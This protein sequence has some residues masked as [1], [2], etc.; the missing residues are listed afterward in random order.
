[1]KKIRV[2]IA[3]DHELVR[4]GLVSIISTEQEFDIIGE[5]KNGREAIEMA[6]TTRPDI[7][8]LDI[9]MPDIDGITATKEIKAN[10]P[11]VKILVLTAFQNEHEIFAAIGAGVSGYILK[12][13]SPE[14]LINSIRT[15]S[16]GQSLLNPAIAAKLTERFSPKIEEIG[17]RIT[18][19]LTDREQEVLGLIVKGY[20][21]NDIAASLR[22]RKE[23]VKTHV[24]S[25]LRKLQQSDRT[26]AAIYA[27]RMGIVELEAGRPEDC[28]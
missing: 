25:I 1:M 4:R 26:Q 14:D 3:D 27:I 6:K 13:I 5:A 7:I 11:E 19:P 22:I 15:I 8:L 17:E 12:D 18:T 28:S 2:L 23:T 21:N 16:Q 10:M 9:R 20:K 24:S